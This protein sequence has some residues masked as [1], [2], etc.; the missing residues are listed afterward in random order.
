MPGY[1]FLARTKLKSEHIADHLVANRTVG[2]PYSDDMIENALA[3]LR[4]QAETDGDGADALAERYPG[5]IARDF[6]GNPTTI[7]ELDALIAYLQVLGT[8]VDFKAFEPETA[9]R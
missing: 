1:P 4:A 3:D 2:V 5:A 8:M 6:D 7:S 9:Q